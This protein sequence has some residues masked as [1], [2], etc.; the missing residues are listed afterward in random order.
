[1]SSGEHD[2]GRDFREEHEAREHLI[3]AEVEAQETL[4]E[5]EDLERGDAD[6]DSA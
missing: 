5:A 2:D 4:E 6:D 1:M 3:D